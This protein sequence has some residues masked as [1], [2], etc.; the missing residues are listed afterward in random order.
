MRNNE[1]TMTP[2]KTQTTKPHQPITPDIASEWID[3]NAIPVGVSVIQ[4]LHHLHDY[5]MNDALKIKKW[6]E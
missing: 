1:S 3:P 2:T 6:L 4:A 5:M